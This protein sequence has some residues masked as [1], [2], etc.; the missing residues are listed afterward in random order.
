L[1]SPD[2]TTTDYFLEGLLAVDIIIIIGTATGGSTGDPSSKS[3]ALGF[4]LG[5]GLAYGLFSP[6]NE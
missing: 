6:R 4:S 3:F 5:F 1:S 2:H